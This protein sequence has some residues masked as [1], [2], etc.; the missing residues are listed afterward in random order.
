MMMSA[1]E[2]LKHLRDHLFHGLPK[3]LCDSMHYLD[4]DTRIVQPQLVT[5]EP[6]RLSQ[7]KRTELRRE[8]E[9]DQLIQ[10]GRMALQV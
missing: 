3:Q 9:Q 5:V 1:S 10:R 2:V 4:D 7:S 6:I 8:S